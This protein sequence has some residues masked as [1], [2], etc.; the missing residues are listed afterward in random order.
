MQEQ[1]VRTFPKQ[2]KSLKIK[3]KINIK[4]KLN[5]NIVQRLNNDIKLLQ[6]KISNTFKKDEDILLPYNKLLMSHFL[7]NQQETMCNKK[8][9]IGFKQHKK[10]SDDLG[11]LNISKLFTENVDSNENN[12]QINTIH[13]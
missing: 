9:K 12:G 11:E 10:D 6:K 3:N 7:P 1:G 8:C 2:N 5:T 13:F 4:H